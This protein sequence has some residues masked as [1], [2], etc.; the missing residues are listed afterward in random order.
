MRYLALVTAVYCSF[1]IGAAPV[2]EPLHGARLAARPYYFP[3]TAMCTLMLDF[4]PSAK[5]VT[6]AKGDERSVLLAQNLIREYSGNGGDASERAAAQ[7]E[8]RS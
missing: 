3:N 4:Q 6:A 2:V 1:A 8:W 7:A 5:T